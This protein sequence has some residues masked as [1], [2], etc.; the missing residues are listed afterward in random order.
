MLEDQFFFS[1]P[2]HL[3]LQ[4]L[5]NW[6]LEKWTVEEQEPVEIE[7][8]FFDTFD[9]RLFNSGRALE[10]SVHK[11]GYLLT[12]R[13]LGTGKILVQTASRSIPHLA[14]DFVAPGLQA[15]FKEALG[16]RA[17]FAKLSI[18]GTT[19]ELRVVD[20]QH[21]TLMRIELRQDRAIVPHSTRFFSL[22]D[23]IYLV[24]LRGFDKIHQTSVH[25]LTGKGGLRPLA[26]DPLVSALGRLGIDAANYSNKPVFKL[27]PN[28]PA[29]EAL[30]DILDRYRLIMEQNLPGTCEDIDPEFLHDFLHAARRTQCLLFHYF[31]AFPSK[32]IK[33]IRQDFDW[34]ENVTAPV[35]SLDIYLGQ[36]DEFLTRVDADHR[37]ALEPLRRFLEAEKREEHRK[38][39]VPLES[40]RYTR[41]MNAWKKILQEK[42]PPNGMPEDAVRPILEIASKG[43]YSLYLELIEK[44]RRIVGT[45][46]PDALLEL[47]IIE[48]RLGYEMETFR[49]LYPE[50]E[51]GPAMAALRQLQDNL[52]S[53]QNLHTQ[54]GSLLNYSK[55]MQEEHR[56][57]P[58]W[59][60]AI[61]LLAADREREERKMQEEFSARYQN[62]AKKSMRK[63]FQ[64]LF[65]PA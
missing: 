55:K 48:K 32:V 6:L 1:A 10:I 43:I 65:S 18:S 25:L 54:H 17:L 42:T 21:K 30:C 62:L 49:N 14:G 20:S 9:W 3:T 40:P 39:R 37:L 31:S 38:M 27:D 19:K 34:L 44:G 4:D 11:P 58:V 24:P 46:S 60:E 5:K 47:Q 51:I 16:A 8:V 26:E 7:R 36:F 53:F 41:M 2:E 57:M 56:T 22:P 35:R 29:Y 13:E 33:L 28:Q 45:D 64:K 23:T 12:L 15:L 63:R 59:L 50:E 52:N 61:Q